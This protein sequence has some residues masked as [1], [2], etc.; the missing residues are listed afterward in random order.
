MTYRTR[1][2]SAAILLRLGLCLLAALSVP[3][4]SA[5]ASKPAPAPVGDLQLATNDPRE[6]LRE[7]SLRGSTLQAEPPTP[8]GT[9]Q[10]A[11]FTREL[12]Q[13]QW[14]AGDPID[15]YVIRPKGVAK[16]PVAI[17]LYG[18]P[19]EG[20]RFRNDTF[21]KLVTHGGVA[22]IGFV[23]ALTGER[24]HDVPMRM[25]FVSE[26]HDSLVKTVHDV[27]MIANYVASRSDLDG[28]RIGIF[29]QGAGATI[30]GLAATV[31]PR[32]QAVDL[33][34]PWGDWP[35]WIAKSKLVPDNERPEYQ[36]SEY[37]KPLEP[38]DPIQWL[39]QLAGRP[40][41]L[42]DALYES[43][44]PPEAKAKIEAALPTASLLVRY[45]TQ[46]DFEKNALA[47]GK[48]VAWIQEQLLAKQSGS[49][50]AADASPDSEAAPSDSAGR[51]P[52]RN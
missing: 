20:D 23:P 51:A 24:Y 52:S 37:L 34:D 45:P 41:K 7:L 21:C 6:N 40:L 30:A 16:P 8:G 44:T 22:A 49:S 29:G 32:I 46:A 9:A 33:L 38:L 5:Q 26:L 12:Y 25:W 13:M 43:T 14:R 31:D 19:G 39:P 48:L 42:D 3:A 1:V 47:D 28:S 10:N 35:N 2:N 18:F 11:D 36:R 27:Q 17:Y 50:T 4:A 15:V